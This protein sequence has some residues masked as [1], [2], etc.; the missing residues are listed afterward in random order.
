MILS[1]RPLVT[2]VSFVF[3]RFPV[4]TAELNLFEICNAR[5][6]RGWQSNG[7]ISES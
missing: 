2:F 4:T 5:N 7:K 6:L 1:L 3:K